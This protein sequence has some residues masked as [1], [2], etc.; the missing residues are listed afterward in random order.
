LDLG[1]SP[2]NPQLPPYLIIIDALDEITD[3]GGSAFLQELLTVIDEYDLRG[4]KFLVTSRPDPE[5]VTLCKSFRSDAVCWLQNVPIEEAESDIRTKLPKLAGVSEL[6][7]LVRQADGLFIYAA[8]AVKY[9]TPHRS[10]TAREQT[11]MLKHIVSKSHKPASSNGATFL[12]DALYRQIMIDAFTKFNDD[13]LTCRLRILY[14]LLCTAERTST[15]IAAALV[16][17]GDDEVAMA[18]VEELHS[19]LYVQGD[20]VFLVSCFVPR[21]HL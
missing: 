1:N 21:F 3:G 9:L 17:E 7:E 16:V 20:R 19:V 4:F 8:K 5:V 10:I 14:T 11:R 6:A 2:H 12:I 13:F 18:V 15:S